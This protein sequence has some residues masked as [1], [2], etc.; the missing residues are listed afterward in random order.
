[1]LHDDVAKW[2]WF[3]DFEYDSDDF[4]ALGAAFEQQYPIQ[5][6]LVG[7]AHCRLFSIKPAVDFALEWLKQYRM[8]E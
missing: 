4:S 1:M 2:T 5:I 6:G 7:N 3:D 8:Y